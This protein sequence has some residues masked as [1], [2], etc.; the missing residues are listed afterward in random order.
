MTVPSSPWVKLTDV[1]T[2]FGPN[3]PTPASQKLTDY[4]KAPTGP[5]VGVNPNTSAIP[6][7]T[8][9]YLHS[10][11]NESTGYPPTTSPA[12]TTPGSVTVP[13]GATIITIESWGAGGAGGP[14]GTRCYCRPNGSSGIRYFGGAGGGSGGF[15]RDVIPVKSS[16]WGVTINYNVG[17]GTSGA[18]GN[19]TISTSVIGYPPSVAAGGG[20]AGSLT[21]N[22]CRPRTIPGTGGSASGGNT[23]NQIGYTGSNGSVSPCAPASAVGGPG[24]A[25]IA[26][27]YGTYGAGGTGAPYTG[28]ITNGSPG[29]VVFHWQ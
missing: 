18:G 7:T 26:G 6:S 4:I 15:V 19:T 21:C 10:F 29:A 8:P 24:A 1:I 20:S 12:Y 28:V 3:G 27:T 17:A 16:Y 13:S 14:A 5:Y 2:E 25:G 23:T 9:V 11:G 22:T